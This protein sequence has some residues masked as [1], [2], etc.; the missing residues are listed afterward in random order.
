M[1]GQNSNIFRR[2]AGMRGDPRAPKPEAEISTAP[3]PH[4]AVP[5]AKSSQSQSRHPKPQILMGEVMAPR[6]IEIGAGRD[7]FRAFLQSRRL[8]PTQWA[9]AAGVPVGEILA[10]LT[11]RTRY[12]SPETVTKLARAAG[13]TPDEMFAD[14]KNGGP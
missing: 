2:S 11:G 7:A 4:G 14:R 3:P 5:A 9:K 13:A 1:M 10:Y 6:G 8:A 12:L